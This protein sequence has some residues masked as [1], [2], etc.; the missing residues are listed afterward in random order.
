M[1]MRPEN[2]DE[3]DGRQRARA[4][5]FRCRHY[6]ETLVHDVAVALRDNGSPDERFRSP[7]AGAFCCVCGRAVSDN[8]WF[9]R[10][11]I[12]D[13]TLSLCSAPC[14]LMFFAAKAA[15]A[16]DH[17]ARHDFQRA[18]DAIIEAAKA[19]MQMADL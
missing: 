5:K 4:A 9:A 2:L 19:A 12:P 16:H 7:P 11:R 15:P 8:G 3:M 17:R 1:N 13:R 10:M 18:R 6:R 14:A